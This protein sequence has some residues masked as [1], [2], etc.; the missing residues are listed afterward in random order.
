MLGFDNAAEAQGSY[1]YT[2]ICLGLNYSCA[3][4][5]ENGRP[6][7]WG[8]IDK[9]NMPDGVMDSALAFLAVSS[10]HVQS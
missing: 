5:A 1:P 7:C 2:S 3:L 4:H 9:S 6:N 10:M 8:E